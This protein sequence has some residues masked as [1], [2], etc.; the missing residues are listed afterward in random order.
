[1]LQN[2]GNVEFRGKRYGKSRLLKT[3]LN[4]NTSR[5]MSVTILQHAKDTVDEFDFE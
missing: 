3:E 5:S 2:S 4:R 1:M